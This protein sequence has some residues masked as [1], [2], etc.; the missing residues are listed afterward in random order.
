VVRT[1]D[2]LRNVG[3]FENVSS[4]A[5]LPFSKLTVIY[6]ENARGKSTLAA[7]MRSL[8]SGR[9]ELIQERARLGSAHPPHIIIG[10]GSAPGAMFQNG[11]WNQ[12]QPEIVV[13]DETFV[14]ENVCSGIEIGTTHRQNLHELI[15]GA[16]GIELARALQIQVDRI[17]VHNRD[18][19]EKENAI[20]AHKTGQLTVDQFCALAWVE[21]L[22]RRI[23]DAEK[24]LAAAREADRI[25]TTE[26]FERFGLPRIDIGALKELLAA[27]LAELDAEALQLVQEHIGRL[28]RNGETWIGQGLDHVEHLSAHERNECPFCAQDLSGSPLLS[29]YRGYFS[30]AYNNLRQRII[31]AGRDFHALQAGDVPVAFERSVREAVEKQAFWKAFTDVPTLNLDTSVIARTWKIAREHIQ[32]LL[33]TKAANPLEV[34]LISAEAEQAVAEHNVHCDRIDYLIDQ[35]MTANTRVE[36]VKEQARDANVAVLISDLANLKA[37]EARY[38]PAVVPLCDA[39]LEEKAAKTATERRR[40]AARGLLNEHREAAFPAYGIAINDFLQRFNASF[41]VGPIDP[42]N[43]RG[44]SAANY[45]LLIDGHPVPL[46][47]N[48]GEASFRNTLSAGDRNTLALAFFFASLENDPQRADKIVVIDDPMTSLDEHRTLHTLQ[49]I[50]RLVHDVSSMIV[51]SHSKPFL[52]GVWSKCQQVQKTALEPARKGIERYQ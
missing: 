42:V 20:S 13:F 9:P 47:A 30:E 6:A 14:A 24:R 26:T 48:P 32:R 15:V 51:L 1:I 44:G 43:N 7:I 36:L 4:G 3:R 33:D 5:Q 38:A 2:L 17:E 40:N 49:E 50:D 31:S 8:S 35:L 27:G 39:Y 25:A 12:T 46:A 37:V 16:Q 22:P 28:G 41:R 45:T 21:D 18:L 10:T 34:V 11:N 29:H 23:D 19:R 52:L